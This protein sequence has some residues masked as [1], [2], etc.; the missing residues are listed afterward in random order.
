M[1]T[2]H[3][4][5][6]PPAITAARR[7]TRQITTLVDAQTKEYAVGLAALTAE[8]GGYERPR[9]ADEIRSLLAEAI[10]ARHKSDPQAYERAVRRGREVLAERE[11]NQQGSDT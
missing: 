4:T 10:V 2:P 11:G 1:T 3:A 8:A 9:E 7:Y 6:A 5:V